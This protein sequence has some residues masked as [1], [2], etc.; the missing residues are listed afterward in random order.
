MRD[1]RD[2]LDLAQLQHE[3]Q[4]Y[5]AN[6]RDKPGDRKK[7][8]RAGCESVGAMHPGAFRKVF[9][10]DCGSA[11]QW[12]NSEYTPMGWEPCLRCNPN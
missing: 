6:L 9:F 10:E 3:K 7:L 12:L 4:G 2:S 11:K 5:I 1:V 8:H